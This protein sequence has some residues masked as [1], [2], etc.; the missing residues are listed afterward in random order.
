MSDIRPSHRYEHF[1]VSRSCTVSVLVDHLQV[2][3]TFGRHYCFLPRTLLVHK[4]V[5]CGHRTS[6]PL[7][8]PCGGR[9]STDKFAGMEITDAANLKVLRSHKG[10]RRN[11][12]RGSKYNYRRPYYCTQNGGGILDSNQYNTTG[13]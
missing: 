6:R 4:P 9:W 8:A 3:P 1:K 12:E 11:C 10:K 2:Y 13:N 7:T 5:L